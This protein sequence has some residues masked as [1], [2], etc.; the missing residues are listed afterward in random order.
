M[1]WSL[2]LLPVAHCAFT[3]PTPSSSSNPSS[4]GAVAACNTISN[5]KDLAWFAD[6]TP[7]NCNVEVVNDGYTP[8][9]SNTPAFYLNPNVTP[10]MD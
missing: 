2:Y 10:Y 9:A 7:K 6:I 8:M 3:S 4:S 1:K 5:W